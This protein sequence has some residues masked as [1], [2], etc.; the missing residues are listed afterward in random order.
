MEWLKHRVKEVSSWH[1]GA[2]IAIGCIILFAGPFA[3]M[4]AWA[5]IAWGLWAIWKKD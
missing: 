1:G 2:L 4:A 3:K 5:S